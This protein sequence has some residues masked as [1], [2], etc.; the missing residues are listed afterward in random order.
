M[1]QPTHQVLQNKGRPLEKAHIRQQEPGLGTFAMLTPRLGLPEENAALA[2]SL[3]Q[4]LEGWTAG[5]QE[6][7]TENAKQHV[8]LKHALLNTIKAT[9]FLKQLILVVASPFFHP[10]RTKPSPISSASGLT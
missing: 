7:A 5:K 1:S 4:I 8:F 6:H 10:P 9:G 2:Q 3:R